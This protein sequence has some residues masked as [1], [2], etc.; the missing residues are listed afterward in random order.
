[1]IKF[2]IKEGYLVKEVGDSEIISNKGSP[3]NPQIFSGIYQVGV[4]AKIP[5][6]KGNS[7]GSP[8]CSTGLPYTEVGVCP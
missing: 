1:M 2:F 7:A 5:S 6:H 4:S 8:D 3:Y